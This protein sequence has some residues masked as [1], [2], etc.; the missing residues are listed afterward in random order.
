MVIEPHIRTLRWLLQLL[1][2][3]PAR[4]GLPDDLPIPNLSSPVSSAL[5]GAL[6]LGG[7]AKLGRRWFYG[8]GTP[9][10]EK[11]PPVAQSVLLGTLPGILWGVANLRS[12]QSIF[13]PWPNVPAPPLDAQDLPK[14]RPSPPSSQPSFE[15]F[16]PPR[17]PSAI[18]DPSTIAESSRSV[19]AAG[20]AVPGDPEM[21]AAYEALQPT[22]KAAQLETITEAPPLELD[23]FRRAIWLDPRI[24]NRLPLHTQ[25]TATA[26]TTLAD[27]LGNRSGWVTPAE[28]GRAAVHMGAGWLSGALVGKALG[29]LAG[30][31]PS[32]QQRLRDV[33]TYAGAVRVL[34]PKLF[35]S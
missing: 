22:V 6:L 26:A 34:M 15:P 11:W 27:R 17:R 28:M 35:G 14:G 29:L 32:A 3:L 16:E 13:S 30:L 25:L 19:P 23:A 4:R 5:M 7:A 24:A 31:P 20:R 18:P 12:G 2:F 10:E 8:K 1:Q 33:G 21:L 9:E